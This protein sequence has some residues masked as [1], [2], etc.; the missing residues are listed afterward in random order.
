MRRSSQT[1][2]KGTSNGNGRE[3]D[4]SIVTVLIAEDD[5]LIRETL[6]TVIDGDDDF[7]V[8]AM[9]DDADSAIRA[10]IHEPPDL[11][12]LDVRMPGGGGAQAAMRI[13]ESCPDVHIVA[14]SAHDD[15]ETIGQMIEAGA[16][17]YITKEGPPQQMLDTLRRCAAGESIFTP[18]SATTLMRQYVKSSQRME[19]AKQLLRDRE[20]RLREACDPSS[21]SSVFQPIVDLESGKVV[22][23]EALTRFN[24]GHE[25]NTAEWFEEAVNLG[26]SVEL[27]I[28]ALA[29]TVAALVEQ[30]DESVKVSVNVSP[31]TLLNAALL[32]TLAPI[33]PSRVVI[34]ITEHAQIHDYEQT[35]SVIERLRA[36]GAKL[37]IDDAGAGFASLR[38]ILDLMP[39]MIKLDIT[40]VRGIDHDQPRR[41]LAAGLISFAN[42]IGAAIVAEGIETSEELECLRK[43]GVHM[44]QGYILARPAP[45]ADALAAKIEV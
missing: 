45:L 17:G 21:I 43:L 34:E 20:I 1:D 26:M 18:R 42:E 44:G 37:A 6:V 35:K 33:D 13:A 28:A 7:V 5:P 4:R 15:E 16:R 30:G 24:C 40:L 41:A 12:L 27:E 2:L 19:A 10:A 32:S 22:M 39:D 23:Y 3:A 31:D 11:A 29:R 38:H 9:A 14:I 36:G 25:L 8:I